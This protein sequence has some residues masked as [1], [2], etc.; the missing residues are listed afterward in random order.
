MDEQSNVSILPQKNDTLQNKIGKWLAII[1]VIMLP[2]SGIIGI[3]THNFRLFLKIGVTGLIL[4]IICIF[5][6][7]EENKSS[8]P[9]GSP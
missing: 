2:C 3:T 9:D 5:L 7:F 6:S 1:G 4:I 8:K